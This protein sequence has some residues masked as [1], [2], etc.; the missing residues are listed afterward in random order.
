MGTNPW[1]LNPEPQVRGNPAK[2]ME[3]WGKDFLRMGLRPIPVQRHG[4]KVAAV[5]GTRQGPD[6]DEEPG[7]IGDVADIPVLKSLDENPA[8]ANRLATALQRKA[9]GGGL[10]GR[11]GSI[12]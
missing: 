7:E 9:V 5:A 2:T 6:S 10:G 4:H 8:T 11:P 1:T 12:G 3:H